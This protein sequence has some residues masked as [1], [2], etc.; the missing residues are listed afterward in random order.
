MNFCEIL[1][2]I[3]VLLTFY[4]YI[5]IEKYENIQ[6]ISNISYIDHNKQKDNQT[7]DLCKYIDGIIYINLDKRTDRRKTI[8]AELD[9]LKCPY[10]RLSA[11][12]VPKNGAKGCAKSHINALNIAKKNKWKNV[13]IIEDDFVFKHNVDY[14]GILYNILTKLNFNFDVLMLSGHLDSYYKTNIDN[15]LLKV[16][17]CV[18]TDA[19]IVSDKFYDTLLTNFTESYNNQ[20]SNKPNDS[21]EQHGWD[22]WAIDQH[23]KKLQPQHDWYIIYP[24][25]GQQQ[26]GFSDIE[27]KVVNYK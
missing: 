8:E 18:K 12:Y 11:T 1:I 10:Q 5:K 15:L 22:I 19:Y 7:I 26:F 9:T 14:K 16:N 25:I 17:K 4:N 23:W 21:I 27:K 20:P 24:T 6:E 3:L 13:L 2:C